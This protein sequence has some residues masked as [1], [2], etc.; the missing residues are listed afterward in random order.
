MRERPSEFLEMN[1]VTKDHFLAKVML[2]DRISSRQ[3]GNNGMFYVER[4]GVFLKMFATSGSGWDHVSISITKKQKK[5][6]PRC[7]NW[8]EM[9]Y[10]KDLFFEE[11]EVVIQYHPAKKD[12]VNLHPYVL[13][14]WK[15]HEYELPTPPISLV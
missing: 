12:Y 9:C 5:G 3:F 15:P 2:L 14:L 4:K 13:H 6:K 7:P 1:R 10:V 8:E 11:T